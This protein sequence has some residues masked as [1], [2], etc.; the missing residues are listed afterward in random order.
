MSDTTLKT[1]DEHA[2]PHAV[3]GDHSHSDTVNLPVIGSV[4]VPGG[5]YTVVFAGLGI[6]TLIEV[7]VSGIALSD[8]VAWIKGLILLAM[9]FGKA[10][11][12]ALFYMHLRKDSRIFAL[13]MIVPLII[14]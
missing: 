3:I 5:I 1:T 9:A 14:V 2:T 8:D 10:A 13:A 12:V 6:L 4:T 7:A 11:L